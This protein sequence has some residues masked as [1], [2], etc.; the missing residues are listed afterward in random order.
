[1]LRLAPALAVAWLVAWWML[2]PADP[3]AVTDDLLRVLMVGVIAG[4]VGWLLQ[5]GPDVWRSAL[6]TSFLLRAGVET[7][8]GALAVIGWT[9]WRVSGQALERALLAGPAAVLAGVATWQG[10]CGVEGT[11]GGVTASWGLR[12]GGLQ[13]PVVPVGYIE[14]AIALGLALW[15]WRV[16]HRPAAGIALLGAY[17]AAR[18]A[19]GFWRP[20][21]A[22]RPTR[23]QLWMLLTAGVLVATA[24]GLRNRRASA[25]PSAP[26]ETGVSAGSDS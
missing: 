24:T 1:M 21:L 13:H 8:I 22:G 5:S 11:C 12:L 14:A 10:L 20:V 6:T 23:D 26:A 4:R 25:P 16:R 17:A 18:V 9:V 2:R 7:G 19:L 3:S 15:A